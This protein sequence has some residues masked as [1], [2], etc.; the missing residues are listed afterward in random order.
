[1]PTDLVD[2]TVTCLPDL[3]GDKC[4]DFDELAMGFRPIN[5][6]DFFTVPVPANSD[7]IPNGPRD[8]AIDITDVLAVLSYAGTYDGDGGAPNPNGVAYDSVK[9][10]CPVPYVEGAVQEEGLC[11]DRSPGTGAN[12]PYDAGPPDGA[13]SIIDVLVVVAQAGLDCSGDP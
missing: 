12:P 11:Y 2:A 1:M 4:S 6:W 7:G 9:G 8:A 13:I 10:S 3:D 5:P